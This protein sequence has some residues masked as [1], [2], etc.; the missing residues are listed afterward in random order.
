MVI[1]SLLTPLVG[2]ALGLW[3]NAWAG[4]LIGFAL[5]QG[6]AAFVRG[7]TSAR[8]LKADPD[9]TRWM[10]RSF[11]YLMLGGGLLG[12]LAGIS[13]ANIAGAILGV[14]LGV[15]LSALVF[16]LAGFAGLRFGPRS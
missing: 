16:L 5:G 8:K 14:P 15:I 12:F 9:A 11:P 7:Y 6:V 1:F 2:S 4:A 3:L 10:N 13:L